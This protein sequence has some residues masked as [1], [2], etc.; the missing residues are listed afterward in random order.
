M[1]LTTFFNT[2]LREHAS[3]VNSGL[4]SIE[5][6]NIISYPMEVQNIKDALQ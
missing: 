5:A 1:N 6:L 2:T 3:L 4:S